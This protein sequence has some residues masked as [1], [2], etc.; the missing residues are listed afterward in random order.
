MKLNMSDI[1]LIEHIEKTLLKKDLDIC[2]EGKFSAKRGHSPELLLLEGSSRVSIKDED[3]IVQ[4]AEGNGT[5]RDDVIKSL[6]KTADSPFKFRK[7]DIVIDEG[8]YIPL[9]VINRIRRKALERLAKS[10]NTIL[11]F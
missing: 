1:Q 4:E 10:K 8:I 11:D 6:E 2:I 5:S 9:S 7:L 3:F